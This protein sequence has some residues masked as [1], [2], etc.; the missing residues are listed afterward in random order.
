MSRYSHLLQGGS[1]EVVWKIEKDIYPQTIKRTN[2]QLAWN[3]I[4]PVFNVCFI[5]EIASNSQIILKKI[6]LC[7]FA[8]RLDVEEE[9]I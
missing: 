2:I 9:V 8:S 3:F 5:D 6:Y 7:Y 1:M 4:S